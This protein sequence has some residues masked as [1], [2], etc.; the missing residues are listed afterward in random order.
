MPELYQLAQKQTLPLEAK[1]RLAI[2][3]IRAWY[4]HWDGDVHIMLCGTR[5]D[6]VLVSVV[7]EVF[8][9]VPVKM[10]RGAHPIVPF[11]VEADVKKRK[12]WL[13]HGCNAFEAAS[14]ECRPLSTWTS[15]DVQAY[16][17]I[18]QEPFQIDRPW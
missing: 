1:V 3:R 14:P 13:K 11:M 18:M 5:A 10:V 12:N 17:K 2:M 9:E 4:I 7:R 8:S 15:E 6:R 16:L